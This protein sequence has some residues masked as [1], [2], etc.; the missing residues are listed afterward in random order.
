M[1]TLLRLLP[2]LLLP[3]L[4]Q[5]QPDKG[6]N[7]GDPNELAEFEGK[8]KQHLDSWYT[9]KMDLIRGLEQNQ[10]LQLDLHGIDP[11]RFKADVLNALR[12][13]KVEWDDREIIVDGVPRP[14]MNYKDP[15]GNLRIHC[16]QTTYAA[17][18]K[19]YDAET[20]YKNEAHEYFAVAGFER[21]SYGV[22]DYPISSQISARLR[23]VES[24]RWAVQVDLTALKTTAD[25]M[26]C[27]VPAL[28]LKFVHYANEPQLE[29]TLDLIRPGVGRYQT[30]IEQSKQ[31]EGEY[32]LSGQ[33][34][35]TRV[36]DSIPNTIRYGYR[37]EVDLESNPDFNFDEDCWGDWFDGDF[38]E[39]RYRKRSESGFEALPTRKHRVYCAYDWKV[40][41]LFPAWQVAWNRL[42]DR[43]PKRCVGNAPKLANE[44]VPIDFDPFQNFTEARYWQDKKLYMAQMERSIEEEILYRKRTS[45]A[46][47]KP[48]TGPQYG[49]TCRQERGLGE[50]RIVPSP[51]N[52][53]WFRI[54]L[55]TRQWNWSLPVDYQCVFNPTK[56][57][58]F[59][60][61]DAS[62]S[63]VQTRFYTKVI[64]IDAELEQFGLK[65]EPAYL[66]V[67]P[68]E[69]NAR[70]C[71]FNAKP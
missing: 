41:Q 54:L 69:F 66:L 25:Q 16:N 27:Y 46:A 51:E 45:K 8:N 17:A 13:A 12:T 39:T 31:F 37:M 40:G 9:I 49:V 38:Y 47:P 4:A 5:A 24:M 71:R 2:L 32:G 34:V 21:N 18:M 11:A 48:V 53:K 20:Q 58:L 68:L 70:E 63:V 44:E 23:K 42:K 7:G 29:R 57:A 36:I 59:D 6:G 30:S 15:L 43:I 55:Q 64:A 22:S 61:I 65:S 14:C 60:C 3:L 28:G 67:D 26:R 62:K 35:H 33:I 56:P 52:P 19:N 1:K 10:H 50:L